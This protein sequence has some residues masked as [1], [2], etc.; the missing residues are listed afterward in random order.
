MVIDTEHE[1]PLETVMAKKK[2][3][4]P[5][6]DQVENYEI[7]DGRSHRSMPRVIPGGRAPEYLPQNPP[8]PGIVRHFAKEK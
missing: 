7:T 8:F 1:T 2:I 3:L 6:V 5:A 4:P